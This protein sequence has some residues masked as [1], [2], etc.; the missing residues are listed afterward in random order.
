[1]DSLN[2]T[3][4]QVNTNNSTKGLF[5]FRINN[6]FWRKRFPS[7]IAAGVFLANAIVP[8][9]M[10][11]P[12]GGNIV[13]GQGSIDQSINTTQ[14]NQ[15]TN[16]LVIDWASFDVNSNESVVFVQPNSQSV[17]VNNVLNNQVS[18][19]SGNIEANGYVVLVNSSGV[20]FTGSSTV[21]VGGLVVSG[22]AVNTDAF[23][24]GDLQFEADSNGD[25]YVIT[26]GVINASNGIVLLGESVQ[27]TG[28]LVSAGLVN[29]SAANDAIL[30]FDEG[31]V[32]GLKINEEVLTN[33]LGVDAAV[34]NSGQI[35]AGSVVLDGRVSS[36][37]FSS[38]VN[39]SG[40]IKAGSIENNGGTIRLTG[41]GSDVINSGQLNAASVSGDGG[42]IHV[43]GDRAIIEGVI[44]VSSVEASGGE[45]RI[46][47]DAVGLFGDAQID[48]SGSSGGGEILIGGDFQGQNPE[49]RN[50]DVTYIGG[51]VSIDASAIENGDGG[52]VIVW[53][54][55]T[56]RFYGDIKAEGGSESGDG[57]FVE[58]SGKEFVELQGS[59]SASA[60]NG[61]A[62]EWLIDPTDITISDDPTSG[63]GNLLSDGNWDS[64]DNGSNDSANISVSD[65]QRTIDGGTNVSIATDSSAAG[66]GD[67]TVAA[68]ITVDPDSNASLTL[69]ADRDININANISANGSDIG[70]LSIFL[71]TLSTFG[72]SISVADGVTINSRGGSVTLEASGAIDIQGNIIAD[73]LDAAA[74]GEVGSNGGD[75][76]ITSENSSVTIGG[77]SMLV[78]MNN[79][80]SLGGSGFGGGDDA[81]F[82]G[83]I[84]IN[85]RTSITVRNSRIQSRT[86]STGV[87]NSGVADTNDTI[88]FTLEGD[89]TAVI[90]FQ[91]DAVFDADLVE[92][93]AGVG[94]DGNVGGS[95]DVSADVTV[96]SSFTSQMNDVV[97]ITTGNSADSVSLS[98]DIL[99][100]SNTLLNV[101]LS[102]SSDSLDAS[103]EGI[104]LEN[105]T[106]VN[107]ETVT[108][109]DTLTASSSSDSFSQSGTNQVTFNGTLFSGVNSVEGNG[110]NT[111]VDL[112][113]DDA[114]INAA[115]D[116]TSNG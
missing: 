106:F 100:L 63:S 9:A 32:I 27:N 16:S 88:R 90:D 24:N 35:E 97:N 55:D 115:S 60:E 11:G 75:I 3:S 96:A 50:A 78:A 82:G 85:S 112:N 93:N 71:D 25:G 39:N 49:I 8:V 7:K 37:L 72:G 67:I 89:S 102:D 41:I 12:T 44:D 113:N 98:G 13:S 34:L 19:I 30:T 40:V 79:I 86:G 5:T 109:T 107:V 62:G 2:N 20:V 80:S 29:L 33:E 68:A 10:A 58:T 92:I 87:D 38:A 47:G 65:I 6:W 94:I 57:G 66:N 73:G 52:R 4:T 54:D 83:L 48:A 111:S 74:L 61:N 108:N 53:A 103:D 14:I 81:G 64:G 99:S 77:D 91:A 59:V 95:D 46:L 84:A 69:T 15:N 1:M 17:A 28:T 23:L 110:T 76:T 56:T 114:T 51:D 21:N 70:S 104:N 101:D 31:G 116:F 26:S 36:D 42:S 45:I 18:T 43:E 105:I 22:L